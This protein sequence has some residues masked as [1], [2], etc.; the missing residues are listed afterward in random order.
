MPKLW[1]F[2]DSFSAPYNIESGKEWPA[3]WAYRHG[4]T[5][6]NHSIAGTSNNHIFF[7]YTNYLKEMQLNDRVLI[8]WSARQRHTILGN[9]S[10]TFK[11]HGY[12]HT[13]RPSDRHPMAGAFFG[14][15][16]TIETENNVLAASVNAAANL[17]PCPLVQFSGHDDFGDS[18]I[19][20][21]DMMDLHQRRYD[22][23]LEAL[24]A[25]ELTTVGHT[26]CLLH[27][28]MLMQIGVARETD[29]GFEVTDYFH[30]RYDTY[31]AGLFQALNR[32]ECN[33]FL[34][35]WHLNERGHSLFNDYYESL[36]KY[37]YDTQT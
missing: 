25:P 12:N 7:K 37:A 35:V 18:T 11:E 20:D 19:T 3:L 23:E 6:E 21:N 30:N 31:T 2:G 26:N 8:C 34:D 14:D 5:L 27:E 36:L 1:V 32:L 4:Y 15:F 17:A 13:V 16:Y 24:I 29:P 28:W 22:P 10:P 33:L 9:S